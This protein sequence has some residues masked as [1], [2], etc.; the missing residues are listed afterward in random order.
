M[1]EIFNF[2]TQ[3]GF[4]RDGDKFT[5]KETQVVRQ[6]V[7]NGQLHNETAELTRT[8]EYLGEG[9]IE[10]STGNKETTYGF[11]FSINDQDTGDIWVSDVNSL[12]T[13]VRI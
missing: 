11:K 13:M 6:V 12:S 7:V 10:D 4:E 8:V 1:E 9:Y 3:N 2:F 5:K